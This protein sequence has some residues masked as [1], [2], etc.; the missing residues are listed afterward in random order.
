MGYVRLNGDLHSGA[1]MW[2]SV[3]VER[4]REGWGD[5]SPTP[6]PSL[7]YSFHHL[8]YEI[9]RNQIPVAKF[10]QVLENRTLGKERLAM[11]CMACC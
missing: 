9:K 6:T 10:L 3:V 8:A 7:I 5:L 11:Y 1:H 4:G 2:T